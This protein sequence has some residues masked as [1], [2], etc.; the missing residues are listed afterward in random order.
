MASQS[1]YERLGGEAALVAALELF[2]GKV[3]PLPESIT[4][5][6]VSI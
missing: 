4:S 6:K 5:F 1:L 2:Y 3:S